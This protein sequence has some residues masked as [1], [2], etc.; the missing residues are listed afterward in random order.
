[1]PVMATIAVFSINT[2]R[3][4]ARFVHFGHRLLKLD[5]GLEAVVGSVIISFDDVG[6]N[7]RI[8]IG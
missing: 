8:V 2:F 3:V 6:A 5:I 7:G 4:V 1:M